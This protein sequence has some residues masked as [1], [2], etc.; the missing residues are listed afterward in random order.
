MALAMMEKYDLDPALIY[1]VGLGTH[2]LKQNF[3]QILR[4]WATRP[5]FYVIVDDSPHVIVAN[6]ETA[7]QVFLDKEHYT[8]LLPNEPGYEKFNKFMGVQTLLQMDGEQHARVR[9]LMNPAFSPKSMAANE[10]GFTAAVDRMLDDIETQGDEFDAMPQY[11]ARLIVEVLLTTMVGLDDERKR[12]FFELHKQLPKTT[13]TKPGEQFP[14]EC[15]IAFENAREM[16]DRLIDERRANPGDDMVSALIQSRDEGD[17]LSDQELFDQIFTVCV[18]ALTGTTVGAG[19][20][21]WGMYRHKDQLEE[22]RQDRSLFPQAVEECLRYS[23]TAGYVTS[24]RFATK[25]TVLDGTSVYAGMPVR[26][27]PQATSFDETKYPDPERFDIHR[28]PREIMA[29]GVGAH[30]CIGH[31]L[32]RL[33]LRIALERLMDRYPD[34][35]L[36]DPEYTPTYVG[37]VGELRIESLPMRLR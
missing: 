4:E 37:A 16:I 22:L 26:I 3:R 25:D 8:C 27:S 15:L 7:K 2:E 12:I 11:A 36:V 28:D 17:K 24:A 23:A 14:E 34:A 6:Y 29:F 21:I 18:A 19:A 30:H 20:V 9:R 31:R 35:H 32:A 1:D 5:P 13:Y 33:A 10:R